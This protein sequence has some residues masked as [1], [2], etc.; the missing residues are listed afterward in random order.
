M[1]KPLYRVRL[2]GVLDTPNQNKISKKIGNIMEERN[3]DTNAHL[4]VHSK[5]TNIISTPLGNK[6]G[7][8][9]QLDLVS[10]KVR[11]NEE[12]QVY[13]RPNAQKKEEQEEEMI[14][15]VHSE[16]QVFV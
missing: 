4:R 10:V 9:I 7:D 16:T 5:V 11:L 13:S 1:T 3:T 6:Q 8:D 14:V 12:K 15:F 2:K